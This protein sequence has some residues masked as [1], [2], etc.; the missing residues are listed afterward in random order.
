MK[1]C[2]WTDAGA[3]A[4][5]GITSDSPDNGTPTPETPPPLQKGVTVFKQETR[6]A[7]TVLTD[8]AYSSEANLQL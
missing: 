2:A 3:R 6:R 4:F 1:L 7:F 5:C 8:G